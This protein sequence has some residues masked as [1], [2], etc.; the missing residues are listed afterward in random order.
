LSDNPLSEKWV[1]IIANERS[2]RGSGRRHVLR[3]V[4][5]LASS[6]FNCEVAWTPAERAQLVDRS[7]HDSGCRCLVGVGGDGTVAAIINERP[8]VP[9]AVLPTGTE[10]LFA[11]HFGMV[12]NPERLVRSIEANQARSI[13]LGLVAHHRFALMASIGF[14]AE[15]ISRH[16]HSRTGTTSRA[17]YVRPVLNASMK[18]QFPLLSVTVLDP[19]GI[20]PLTG[21]MAFIFNLPTYALGLPVA[22]TASPSDGLLDLV[23]F[24]KPGPFQALRYLWL[25][26]RGIHLEQDGVTHLRI[27]KV[28]VESTTC[29][30]VQLD[31]DPA[32]SINPSGPAWS[33]SVLP[34][35]VEIMLP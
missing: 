4:T 28:T 31:G 35:A 20:Q 26:A 7:T 22:P 3:L 19:P 16:H 13:D 23:V 15:V 30:P 25:V 32:G 27:R 11:R 1:G 9:F 12:R 21:S 33:A 29:V 10:N 8:S 2:G 5:A 34:N 6:G 17:A 14:D 24:Q 18:Y